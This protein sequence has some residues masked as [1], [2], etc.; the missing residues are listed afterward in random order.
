M[1]PVIDA[2]AAVIETQAVDGEQVVAG[3]PTTGSVRLSSLDGQEC[4]IWEM[5]VG[6][7][8]DVEADEI[9]VVV[10]GAGTVEFLDSSITLTLAPGSVGRL[11]AGMRTIWTV[12]ETLRKIYL[13][14]EA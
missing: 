4:G 12:T 2:L 8:S 5:S 13:T 7:M 14:P 11:T 10:A 1:I 6:A 9:F 3:A